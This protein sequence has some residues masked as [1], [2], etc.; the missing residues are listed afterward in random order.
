[1]MATCAATGDLL[2]PS[3]PLAPLDKMLTGF[4]NGDAPFFSLWGT[5]TA[6]PAQ[7]GSV[8]LWYLAYCFGSAGK[9]KP[10]AQVILEESDLAVMVDAAALPA[11]S[12][13]AIPT[14]AFTGEGARFPNA[15]GVSAHVVWKSNW[16]PAGDPD[17]IAEGG[18]DAVKPA[19]WTAHGFPMTLA[20]DIT[21]I[22]PMWG[23]KALLGEQTK[24]VAMSSYR[25]SSVNGTA[26]SIVVGLRGKSGEKVTLLLATRA[27]AELTCSTHVATI[28]ASGT[29][30]VTL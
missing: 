25:F 16:H 30:T 19:L 5:Y 26:S 22:A 21:N 29:T 28:G 3:Y 17:D 12:F 24:I 8:N 9:H 23:D 15:S 14:G 4:T 13:G 20:D 11:P 7:D 6:V 10:A 27:G 2:Q 1:V 18:C